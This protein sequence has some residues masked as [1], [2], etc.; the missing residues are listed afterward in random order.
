MLLNRAKRRAGR[1]GIPF[2]ITEADVVIPNLCPVFGVPLAGA[3]EGKW[4]P[5]LDRVDSSE[6]YVPGNVA[7]ISYLANTLKNSGTAEQHRL[8]ADWIDNVTKLETTC[9]Q[10]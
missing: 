5:S 7:V 1:K 10:S 4:A 3:G 6:G 2:G 9:A 8:I